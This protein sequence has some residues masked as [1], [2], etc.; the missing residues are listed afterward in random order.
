MSDIYDDQDREWYIKRI[1][2]LED[3]NE[4]YK[5]VINSIKQKLDVTECLYEDS[6]KENQALKEFILSMANQFE[7]I[8][9]KL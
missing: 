3:D 7:I 1:K 2:Q 5:N 9:A 4:E 6:K 8:I